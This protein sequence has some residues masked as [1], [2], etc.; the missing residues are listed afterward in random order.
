MRHK[1]GPSRYS[2][3]CPRSLVQNWQKAD[4]F[5]GFVQAGA[6]NHRADL[7]VP[8][9]RVSTKLP[10]GPGGGLSPHPHSLWLTL[11]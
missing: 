5:S 9:R 8:D 11:L 3:T 4:S 7:C 1:I 2:T 6:L 10:G